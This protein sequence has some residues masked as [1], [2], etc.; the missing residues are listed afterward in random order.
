M[1]RIYSII[2]TIIL[3]VGILILAVGIWLDVTWL[4]HHLTTAFYVANV[5]PG[6]LLIGT[7]YLAPKSSDRPWAIARSV[8]FGVF[9][10]IVALVFAVFLNFG[11]GL[12]VGATT[13]VRDIARYE[14]TLKDY[15]EYFGEELVAH[16]PS[17]IPDNATR[18]T[19]YY[20]PSFLQGGSL[21]RLRC[22]LPSSQIDAVLHEY[23]PNAKQIQTSTGSILESSTRLDP[24]PVSRTWILSEE[25]S[26][27]AHEP[28]GFLLL[29]LGGEPY[30]PEDWNHGETYG[31]AVSTERQEV[32]YWS[33][34]W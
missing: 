18:V 32:I 21:L 34:F 12:I 28:E 29:I 23:V 8:G 3:I 14:E 20:L 6:L 24:I 27:M 30:Q 17:H 1:P 19:F 9:V 5:L 11:A 2:R 13:P 26:E 31:V 15:G 33:E 4:P 25:D 16:F 10:A 22:R 7:W